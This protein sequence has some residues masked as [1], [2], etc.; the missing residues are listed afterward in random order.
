MSGATVLVLA[1]RR[2]Q[3]DE[4]RIGLS[5]R[6]RHRPRDALALARRRLRSSPG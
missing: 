4:H 5:Q 3:Q 6:R 2:D 1:R